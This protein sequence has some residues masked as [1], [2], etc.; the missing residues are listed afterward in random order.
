MLA[1]DKV[2]WIRTEIEKSSIS[3]Q[4]LKDD[5]LDHFCCHVEHEIKQGKVF[6]EAYQNALDQ[7]CPNGF[8]E[9]QNETI[10]LLNFKK[11]M[12]MKKLM[13]AI[14][15]ISSIAVCMGWLF[16]ILHWPGAGPLLDYGFLGFVFVFVPML[17]IDRYKVN[18]SKAMSDKLRVILGFCSAIIVGLSV[19]F[20][21]MHLQGADVLLILAAL[22][23]SFGFLPFL[24]FNMYKKSME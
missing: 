2:D 21:M 20:K 7:I 14:G 24:F 13:Y 16:R 8:D 23:F 3:V 19:I 6:D 22:M 17:T 1:E 18:I 15:L 4:D 9:I 11:I 10:F 5:L 12:I